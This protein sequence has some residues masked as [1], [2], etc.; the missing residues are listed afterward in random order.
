MDGRLHNGD[1][2]SGVSGGDD[3]KIIE[4]LLNT[5]MKHSRFKES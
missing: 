1:C 2:G 3:G 4:S 5:P